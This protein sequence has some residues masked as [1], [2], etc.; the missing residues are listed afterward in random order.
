MPELIA[1]SEGAE[2]IRIWSAGCASGEEAYSLAIAFAEALGIEECAKRVKI[3]GTDV[4]EEALRDARAGQYPAKALEPMPAE[5]RDRYFERNGSS[6]TFRPDLRRRVIFGRHDITRDAPISRLDLLVCRN[7][8]MYFN[9][10]TQ[11]QVIDR[12]HFALRNGGFLLLGK[13]ELLVS[14]GDRFE[15]VSMRQ[16]IF[17]RRPGMSPPGYHS[18]P[19]R[20]DAIT[21]GRAAR[22]DPVLLTGVGPARPA[23]RSSA[24]AR[25]GRD[26]F[27]IGRARELDA[28]DRDIGGDIG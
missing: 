25:G 16:R 23:V 2:E 1:D 28:A 7:T 15:V 14:D 5:M 13:A 24:R 22:R 8:L 10:E 21:S 20:L 4:D 26:R 17:R 3:Y 6:F 12:F 27:R 19:V 11:D 9:V 18:P